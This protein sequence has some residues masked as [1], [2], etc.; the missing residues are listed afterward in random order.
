MRVRIAGLEEQPMGSTLRRA[1]L[2]RVVVRSSLAY[3]QPN[4]WEDVGVTVEGVRR[5]VESLVIVSVTRDAGNA[6]CMHRRRDRIPFNEVNV[7]AAKCSDVT[8]PGDDPA[9]KLALHRQIEVH[10]IGSPESRRILAHINWLECGEVDR[11][12]RERGSPDGRGA[13]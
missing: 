3:D 11:L 1:Q 5:K 8:G 13:R 12:A 4:A 9:W 6:S 7:A 2:Q 10:L